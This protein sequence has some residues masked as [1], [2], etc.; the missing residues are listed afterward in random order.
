MAAPIYSGG[1]PFFKGGIR[2]KYKVIAPTTATV[3]VTRSQSN[4]YFLMNQATGITFTLPSA[5][6]GLYF[7][8]AVTVSVTAAS[9]KVIVK[10]PL[11]EFL[12][13]SLQGYNG[14]S[15]D[16]AAAFSGD[17]ATHVAVTQQAAGSNA[18]GGMQG[19][20]IQFSCLTTGLWMVEGTYIANTTATT[21]F[22]TS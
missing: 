2:T 8:F 9:Y 20:F 17:G 19:S 15:A 21:P 4:A 11:T 14:A 13:G 16:A 6:A 22:A 7:T 1:Y 18:T 3:A 12:I 10:N 5:V